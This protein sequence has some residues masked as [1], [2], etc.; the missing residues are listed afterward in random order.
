MNRLTTGMLVFAVL[1]LLGCG[2]AT[3]PEGAAQHQKSEIEWFAGDVEAAFALAKDAG[4]PVFLY[5]GA[6]WCPPC[7]NLKKNFFSKA[8]FIEASRRFVPVYLDG[9]TERAQL[10]A[11]KFK[12]AGYPTVILFSPTGV[13]LFR[14]PS[15]V[16][17]EQYGVLLEAAISDFRPVQEILEEVMANGPRQAD[18]RDLELIAFHSWAQDP[19]TSLSDAEAFETFWRCFEEMPPEA[20]R[21]RSRFMILTLERAIPRIGVVSEI[22]GDGNLVVLDD[23]RRLALRAGLLELL[24]SPD[25]WLENKVFL[26]LQSR[27]AVEALEPEPSIGRDELVAA[28]DAA[29]VEMQ[30][31][32]GFSATEQL[33]AFVP[34]FE[35]LS[36]QGG[37]E[38]DPVPQVLKDKVRA[39]ADR[40]VAEAN[41]P[42]EFQSTLNMTVWLLQMAGLRDEAKDLLAEHLD[43]AV[44]PHYFLSL[45]GDLSVDDPEIAL[46][47]HRKAFEQAG[48]SSSGIKW[49]TS[50]VLRLIQ[51]TPDDPASINEASRQLIGLMVSNEDA[52]AGRN[53]QYL[54]NLEEAL[55]EWAAATD[56]QEIIEDL[57]N[58]ISVQ[59]DRFGDDIGAQQLERC[60]AFLID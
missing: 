39:R 9:D 52:F 19:H 58:E 12:I 23:E 16:S 59:C 30:D 21:L 40:V 47:W 29:A 13:E 1:G 7:H 50:Y 44:A 10:W 4:K 41:D 27:R 35:L 15:D 14:M 51:V 11:E 45:L 46:G 2:D 20:Q 17:A 57:R 26:T 22:F 36:I 42:G 5:W 38:E 25:L 55:L 49:G 53:V 43:D 8:E 24:G 33:M 3:P 54:E 18:P 60:M 28:W 37:S 34:E 6:E 31:H 32:P 48:Q 56:N